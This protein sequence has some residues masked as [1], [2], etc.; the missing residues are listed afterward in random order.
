MFF[1]FLL[2]FFKCNFDVRVV[3]MKKAASGVKRVRHTKTAKPLYKTH[4]NFDLSEDSED[5]ERVVRERFHA[6]A[7]PPAGG[8][9]GAGGNLQV[10]KT[11]DMKGAISTVAPQTPAA[12]PPAG[13]AAAGIAALLNKYKKPEE[14]ISKYIDDFCKYKLYLA[15]FAQEN[16]REPP[17]VAAGDPPPLVNDKQS[18]AAAYAGYNEFKKKLPKFKED[19][20]TAIGPACDF[21]NELKS[22]KE[23]HVVLRKRQLVL[24]NGKHMTCADEQV[25]FLFTAAHMTLH[26]ESYLAHLLDDLWTTLEREIQGMTFCFIYEMFSLHFQPFR[27]I[28]QR[29]S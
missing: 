21:L 14:P 6:P 9:A 10:S 13:G 17:P 27:S 26:F 1:Q 22:C 20:L 12:A 16:T 28:F 29:S 8:A 15:Y 18:I 25:L 24:G 3:E 23:L 7:A 4:A 19:M 5:E 11:T 2:K